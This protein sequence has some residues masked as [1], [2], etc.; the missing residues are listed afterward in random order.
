M[1]IQDLNQITA[2]T[3]RVEAAQQGHH[4]ILNKMEF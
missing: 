2:E 3:K 1:F 4:Q